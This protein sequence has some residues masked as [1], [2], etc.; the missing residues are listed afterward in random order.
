MDFFASKFSKYN[1]ILHHDIR[2]ENILINKDHKVKIANFG[3][4][5]KFLELTDNI[6]HIVEM[7]KYMAPEKLFDST[8]EFLTIP[9]VKFTG[10]DNILM[11]Q[12]ACTLKKCFSQNSFLLLILIISVWI[13]LRGIFEVKKTY[14][15][16][17]D[18]K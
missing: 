3:L 16:F 1:Q 6:S 17:R 15:D 9:S 13:L 8:K 14:S 2:S 18:P 5:K 7:I 12:G 10:N 4:S 11:I